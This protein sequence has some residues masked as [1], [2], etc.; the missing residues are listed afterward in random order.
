[1]THRLQTILIVLLMSIVLGGCGPSSESAN[2]ATQAD[3]AVVHSEKAAERMEAPAKQLL[4]RKRGIGKDKDLVVLVTDPQTQAQGEQAYEIVDISAKEQ[5]LNVLLRNVDTQ[6][7]PHKIVVLRGRPLQGTVLDGSG[8]PVT[9]ARVTL[10]RRTREWPR[11]DRQR[12]HSPVWTGTDGRFTFGI[13]RSPRLELE[14]AAAG[15]ATQT[16][17]PPPQVEDSVVRMQRGYRVVGNVLDAEDAP[18]VDCEVFLEARSGGRMRARRTKTDTRGRF[19]FVG[20]PA[21]SLRLVARHPDY[22]PAILPRIAGGEQ[23]FHTLEFLDQSGLRVSGAVVDGSHQRLANALVRIYPN[24]PTG[25]LTVP[26]ESKTNSKGR[27]QIAGLAPG[28]YKIEIH[29]PDYS[30]TSRLLSLKT[31]SVTGLRLVLP[32]R[33]KLSGRLTG[34]KNPL[35]T[36]LRVISFFG[37]IASTTLTPDG[38][39]RFPGSGFSLGL[40]TLELEEGDA[41]FAATGSRWQRVSL[42]D[43]DKEFSLSTIAASRLAGTVL[44]GAGKPVAG[45]QVVAPLKLSG[46]LGL[47]ATRRQVLAVTDREGRYMIRGMGQTEVALGFLGSGFAFQQETAKAGPSG[48][49]PRSAQDPKIRLS[50]PG[51]IRGRITRGNQP[52]WGALVMVNRG[53]YTAHKART[54][55]DGHYFL[56]GLPPGEHSVRVKFGALPME[57]MPALIKVAPGQTVG[58][59]DCDLPSRRIA[60]RLLDA[61]KTPMTSLLVETPSGN[62]VMTGVDG[63]F[64]L[65]IPRTKTWLNVR[66]REGDPVIQRFAVRADQKTVD[67]VVQIAPRARLEAEVRFMPADLPATGVVVRLEPPRQAND[68][69]Q[70]SKAESKVESKVPAWA[71]ALETLNKGF[72]RWS[73][74]ERK[75]IER[76]VDLDQGL[77]EL[78]NL[79]NRRMQLTIRAKGYLPHVVLVELAN[80]APKDLGVVK[81]RRGARVHGLIVEHTGKPLGG[82]RVVLGRE[83]ELANPAA[84]TAY[85]TDALGRFM[86]RGISQ[87]NRRIYVAADGFATRAYDLQIPRDSLRRRGNPVRIEMQTGATI[88]VR[89]E[90]KWKQPMDYVMVRLHRGG[91]LIASHRTDEAGRVVFTH[92]AKDDYRVFVQGRQRSRDQFVATS[93]NK[94]YRRKI[95]LKD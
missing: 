61:S 21:E 68:V 87:A 5:D 33:A 67:V 39:F 71:R 58:G 84:K 75:V 34:L 2:S 6:H 45:V 57:Y 72:S 93:G 14:V 26:Y 31:S 70:R 35:Q 76:W 77:L 49:K 28:A 32:Y 47:L 83:S 42:R 88:E 89:V 91:E 44:D 16:L 56:R 15:Y 43:E 24:T 50:R 36:K 90:D 48:V 8:N 82:A 54:N 79:P 17:L 11:A 81:L 9:R 65:N 19:E 37:E 3:G 73:R 94:I 66:L 29:H 86:A 7:N 41:C 40:A 20:V 38:S 78:N 92:L 46:N 13:T 62:S 22:Q 60:G 53:P 51:T 4:D 85:V 27:V 63:T 30:S 59:V 80:N 74:Y 12:L 95:V 52:V 64:E 1:M 69:R 25:L 18:C 23:R 55:K 10:F